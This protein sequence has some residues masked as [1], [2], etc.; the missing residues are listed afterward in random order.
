M[1]H[2]DD[3]DIIGLC[4]RTLDESAMT[5]AAAHL[6]WC[7]SCRSRADSFGASLAAL[8]EWETEA[9]PSSLLQKALEVAEARRAELRPAKKALR[10]AG[11][12]PGDTARWLRL[13][14]TLSVALM[15][16]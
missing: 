14:V 3:R 2:L 12:F 5:S 9:P 1:Y 11:V 13:A 15:L 10:A 16:F 8:D 6:A 7:A 4:Y